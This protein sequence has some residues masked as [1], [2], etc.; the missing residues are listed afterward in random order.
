M[1]DEDKLDEIRKKKMENLKEQAQEE[2]QEKRDAVEEQSI[3]DHLRKFLT[4]D[5]RQRLNTAELARPELVQHV[6]K[7]LV[8]AYRA[9]KIG[10]EL[11]E[12]DVRNVLSEA[13]KQ[14]SQSF[15]IQRR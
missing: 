10:R 14:T 7:D 2:Q 6:K 12:D 15:D 1:T 8:R 3:D 13:N 4:P 9:G 5:A 11:D